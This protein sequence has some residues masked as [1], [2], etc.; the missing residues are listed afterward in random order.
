[1]TLLRGSRSIGERSLLLACAVCA[2]LAAQSPG[3]GLRLFGGLQATDA[4]L[5][6][7][8][9]RIVH[10]WY[11][12]YEAVSL[13]LA[14]DGTLFRSINT[15][16][17]GG[18]VT[19]GIQQLA[20]DGTVLWEYR[21]DSN[22]LVMHH[23]FALMPNG[24]VLLI[25]WERIDAAVAE[26]HGRDP[27][28]LVGQY[29][30]PDR[31]VEVVP[32]GRIGGVVVWQWRVFDHLVQDFDPT[33]LDYGPVAEHPELIDVNVP[34]D[35][36]VDWNHMNG[37]DYDPIH[38]WVIVSVPR[39]NEI[40]IIDHGTTTAEAAS[41]AGG[42]Q[43]MG[44]DLLYRWGNPAMYRAGT[45]AD[46]QLHFQHSPHV[47]SPG[48]P[49]AGHLLVFDNQDPM[50][51]RVVELVL[52]IDQHGHLRME[53]NGTFGP[54]MPVWQYRD[55]AIRSAIMSSCERLPN[56][57]TLI[58]AGARGLIRE[59][60]AAGTKVL[61]FAAGTMV[62]QARYHE[63][64]LFPGAAGL[65]RAN[66]GSVQLDLIAGSAQSG[67]TFVVLGSLTGTVPG[68]TLLGRHL[69]L[70]VDDY[71][72]YM[73]SPGAALY[74]GTVGVL[75][76]DGRA[77]ASFRAWPGLLPPAAVGLTIHH[78]FGVLDSGGTALTLTSNAVP[79][80]ILP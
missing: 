1:M 7:G 48:R 49:G 19:G 74:S 69:P 2:S 25:V 34:A 62:F 32:T 41:H 26:A 31:V 37:I 23:D 29:F 38:D 45:A 8:A 20:L 63:T 22:G 9:G 80:T 11:S 46:Q 64:F 6:D 78:A 21:L 42:R 75:D 39:Q 16:G 52:P 10:S 14:P 35:C 47:I 4:H 44:G 54:A 27:S 76:G 5:V 58:C 43:G 51:S 73:A 12:T 79:L 40:W 53:P 66:G 33:K 68:T 3:E 59:V 77:S 61:D 70:N 56:G 50:G 17:E 18:G 71:T 36:S 30:Q 15:V 55:L 67:R 24:H 57:N 13:Q 28:S 65:S 72:A 60:D